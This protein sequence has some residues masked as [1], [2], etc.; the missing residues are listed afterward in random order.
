MFPPFYHH[1]YNGF[2]TAVY[3]QLYSP[4]ASRPVCHTVQLNSEKNEKE[5]KNT[6][7]GATKKLL[8]HTH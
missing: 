7:F 6:T 2:I 5:D 3:A 1:L 8:A 4:E